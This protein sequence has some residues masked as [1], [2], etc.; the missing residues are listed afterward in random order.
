MWHP[1]LTVTACPDLIVIVESVP[2]FGQTWLV[3][4]VPIE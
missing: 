4:I 1:G 3:A 2:A